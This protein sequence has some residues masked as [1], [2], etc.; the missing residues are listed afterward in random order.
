MKSYIIIY[1]DLVGY[2]KNNE[3]I[4]ISL[5]K[6]FQ[7]QIHHILYDEIIHDK[8]I[9]IP[10]G[11]GMI[12]GLEDNMANSFVL[13]LELV[14]EMID[15][16]KNNNVEIRSAIH[17]G[18]V[19]VLTDINRNKN[20]VGNTINDAAR[21]LSGADNGSVI[22]SKTFYNKYL[23][24]ADFAL[25]V[26]YDINEVLSYI[27]VDEDSVIDKHS[28]EH[29]VYNIL[30]YK[31]DVQYGLESKIL[32]KFFTNI[33]SKDYPKKDNLNNRFLKKVKSCESLTLFGIY[34]PSTP[35]ILSNIEVNQHRTV[36]INI[37]YASDA[38]KDTIENFFG[39]SSCNLNFENKNQS[40][41]DV[42]KW[43]SGHE[44][45]KNIKLNLFEY[46]NF[47]P[48]G[49]SMIDNGIMGKGFIHM[50]NYV[51]LVIP[52]ETPYIEVEWKT[53]TMP[54]IYKF[55]NDYIKENIVLNADMK[56]LS[57]VN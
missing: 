9:L 51:P 23:R 48:F 45:S 50:S 32:N 5:F 18:E 27:L 6:K 52:A 2:S 42:A 44:Y 43:Y 22:I 21:M 34:H 57:F 12:I 20:I 19:N 29:F 53:K 15:W 33:Y 39:S 11:D 7:K 31:N 16:T 17:V 55:Y 40:I 8:C 28:F 41:L 24:I 26:K 49:F 37:Y 56:K 13:S 25:G 54:P 35:H 3:P 1:L 10:T 46:N 30:I 36:E 38:L 4:Q 47:Y 14:T